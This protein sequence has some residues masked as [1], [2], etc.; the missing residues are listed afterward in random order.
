MKRKIFILLFVALF[1]YGFGN[2]TGK[3][4]FEETSFDFG[5]VETNQKVTHVF[6]FT[7][8][9]TAPLEIKKIEA[10][11]GCT[12]T[13]L[14]KK[15]LMPGEKGKLEVTLSTGSIPTKLVRRVYVHSSDPDAE[16]VKLVVKADVQ[17]IK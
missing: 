4:A 8:I 12:S 13:L 2:P 6:V 11:C 5:K 1:T 3:I 15:T 17:P 9:G 7:N 10:P 16:M 14:S